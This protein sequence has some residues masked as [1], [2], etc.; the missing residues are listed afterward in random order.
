[1]KGGGKRR[2]KESVRGVA[3]QTMQ[4]KHYIIVILQFSNTEI[5]S[6]SIKKEESGLNI[7][8]HHRYD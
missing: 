4:D 7:F 3:L 2:G 8:I 6:S 1:M 5:P